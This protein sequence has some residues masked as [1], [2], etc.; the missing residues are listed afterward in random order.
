MTGIRNAGNAFF[1]QQRYYEARRK[2]RKANR[3]YVLLRRRYD[4]QEID[5]LRGS[6]SDLN[7]IDNFSVIN[8]VNMAA[9]ELKLGEYANAKYLCSEVTNRMELHIEYSTYVHICN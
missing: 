8:N 2:Y 4:C 7:K 6:E 1:A 9:T 5:H 3:Y